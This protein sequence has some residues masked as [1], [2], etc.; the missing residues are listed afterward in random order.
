MQLL[1]TA[2]AA[3]LP[4]QIMSLQIRHS[5]AQAEIR[6]EI[7]FSNVNVQTAS[8]NGYIL[9]FDSM[10]VKTKERKKKK[11]LVTI[12]TANKLLKLMLFLE[13]WSQFLGGR[14]SSKLCPPH[15][16]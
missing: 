12:W 4:Q 5:G 15:S 10:N 8:F 2:Q 1:C 3:A 13:L 16:C 6:E 9:F 14:K 11:M 7:C